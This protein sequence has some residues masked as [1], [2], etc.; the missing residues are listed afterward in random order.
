[1]ERLFAALQQP[2]YA[3]LTV[4]G[5]D[6]WHPGHPADS[7]VRRAFRRDQQRDKGLGVALGADA[8]AVAEEILAAAGFEIFGERSDWR[9]ARG[10]RSLGRLFS[11]MTASAAINAVPDMAGKINAWCKA[12]I[13]QAQRAQLAIRIGHRD[14]LAIPPKTCREPPWNGTRR[15]V[16]KSLPVE[17]AATSKS[18]KIRHRKIQ[19]LGDVR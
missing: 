1:M 16:F 6:G 4:D 2:F 8:A 5:Q 17:L 11:R 3:S 14:L 13:C 12:R 9:I 15:F 10:E 19:I 18:A 7:V